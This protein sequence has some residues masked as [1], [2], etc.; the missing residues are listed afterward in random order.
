M[1][2][3]DFCFWLQG[4]FEIQGN[5]PFPSEPA[6]RW[7][8]SDPQIDMIRNHL[9]MVFIH[10]IDPSMKPTFVA[11]HQNNLNQAHHGLDHMKPIK[12]PS[13]APVARC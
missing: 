1:T 4:F 8:L 12:D 13:G 11:D 2:S 9:S 5:Q 3:R 7:N 10:E 6:R